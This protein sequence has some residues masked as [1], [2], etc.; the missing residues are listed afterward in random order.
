MWRPKR[1][2][3]FLHDTMSAATRYCQKMVSQTK[4]TEYTPHFRPKWQNLYPISD[5]K[6]L[7]MIPFGW[8]IHLISLY[9][10]ETRSKSSKNFHRRCCF[11][12]QLDQMRT[13][14]LIRN[15]EGPGKDERHPPLMFAVGRFV[16]LQ[17]LGLF[18]SDFALAVVVLAIIFFVTAKESCIFVFYLIR[19]VKFVVTVF[20][21]YFAFCIVRSIGN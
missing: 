14:G 12:S 9:P 10:Y 18:V 20:F 11:W 2:F 15:V 13:C 17:T 6:C 5:K 21:L 4:Q 16:G 7:K 8:H 1:C 3:F 19:I